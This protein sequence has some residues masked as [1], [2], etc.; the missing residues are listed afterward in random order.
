MI[1]AKIP[2]KAYVIAMCIEGKQLSS[3]ELA[4]KLE[5]ASLEGKSS[6]CFVVG[7]SFGLSDK[8]KNAA[9]LRLSMSRLTFP[10]QLA[11]V[12]LYESIYRSFSIISGGKYHK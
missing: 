1:F 11:R 2:K 3:E 6:I 4:D 8:V 9:D 12:M 7:S 5:A 10:H